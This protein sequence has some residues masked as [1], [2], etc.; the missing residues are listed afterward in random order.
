[1]VRIGRA[2]YN[3]INILGWYS[4]VPGHSPASVRLAAQL[5]EENNLEVGVVRGHSLCVRVSVKFGLFARNLN[6]FDRPSRFSVN[7][8]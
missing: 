4:P 1:M 5:L 6:D 3:K 2:L 8:S 7:Q